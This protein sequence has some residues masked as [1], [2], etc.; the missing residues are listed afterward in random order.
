MLNF[1]IVNEKKIIFVDPPYKLTYNRMKCCVDDT[2]NQ[3]IINK[4][5]KLKLAVAQLVINL[6]RP[7]SCRAQV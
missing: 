7:S 3:F 1:V 2:K 4:A 5:H 6:S